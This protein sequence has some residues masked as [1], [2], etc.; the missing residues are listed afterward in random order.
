MN[1]TLR[2]TS[3]LTFAALRALLVLSLITG[4][5]YPLV[6]TGVAQGAFP[7][8][9]NG[10]V[11]ELDGREVGSSLVGQTWNDEDGNPDP[12]WFQPRPSAADYDA[13]ASGA[14]NLA[15]DSPE[16]LELVRERRA[17]VAAFNGVP[18]SEVPVD[19]V[20][21]SGSGLD[22]HISPRYARLQADRVARARDLDGAAV[23]TLVDDAV[24][25]RVAGFL[26][27][28]RVNV[29]QLNLDLA[30]LDR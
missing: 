21:A 29:L 2:N 3:R 26:G 27:E 4:V 14:S 8:Q 10:S 30:E 5:L 25:S 18:E 1:A 6:V 13:E 9:A 22:P 28:P 15:A 19:A 23:R 11:V 24:R 16:L 12:R 20:T 17:R 7:D